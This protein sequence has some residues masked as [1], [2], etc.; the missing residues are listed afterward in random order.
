MADENP[1]GG[2]SIQFWVGVGASLLAA[3]LWAA[4]GSA[5]EVLRQP[6]TLPLWGYLTILTIIVVAFGWALFLT[7]KNL[8]GDLADNMATF[9]Q[10][11]QAQKDWQAT[12]QERDATHGEAIEDW[13]TAEKELNSR[14]NAL[15]TELE[16]QNQVE[17]E[18]GLYYRTTDTGRRQPF[19]R[20]CWETNERLTT[21]V[22]TLVYTSGRRAYNCPVCG[23]EHDLPYR[24]APSDDDTSDGED[25]PF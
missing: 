5:F 20:I 12:L 4:L 24:P 14:I 19:C 16:L 18:D 1:E 25:I 15:Q 3:A 13:A 11:E 2:V 21:I 23:V 10:W 8:R 22:G 17:F 7:T 9:K 6:L